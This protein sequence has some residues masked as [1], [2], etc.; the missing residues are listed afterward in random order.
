MNEAE[1]RQ[2]LRQAPVP[3]MSQQLAEQLRFSD[4]KTHCRKQLESTPT[5]LPQWCF[6]LEMGARLK[7]LSPAMME[8]IKTL[9]EHPGSDALLGQVWQEFEE[10]GGNTATLPP[11]YQLL[12]AELAWR[13][14]QRK[15][16]TAIIATLNASD[17]QHPRLEK[18]SRQLAN[19]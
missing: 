9:R 1:K 13:Q 16:V 17:W 4:A 2:A 7:Q 19:A 12:L 6:F 18:L 11:P 10:Q 15:K 14:K 3:Q 5:S 8:C